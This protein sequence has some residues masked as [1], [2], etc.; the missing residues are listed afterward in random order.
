MGAH[1]HARRE[2]H[3]AVCS[4][5]TIISIMTIIVIVMIM[6]SNGV[7]TYGVTAYGQFSEFQI[8]FCGP[9]PANLKFETVRTHKQH[10]CF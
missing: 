4:V 6:T 2:V 8:C 5:V 10:I 9:D 3:V 1:Q 7:G